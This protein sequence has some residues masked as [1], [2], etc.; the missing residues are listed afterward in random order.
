MTFPHEQRR[1]LQCLY[2]WA[3]PR[4]DMAVDL[5]T[6]NT[7]VY[8]RGKG[9]VLDEPYVVAQDADTGEITIGAD[10]RPAARANPET[11][12]AVRPL[13][14]SVMSPTSKPRRCDLRRRYACAV[15]WRSRGW[16]WRRYPAVKRAR[17]QGGR[18]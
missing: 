16:W 2:W 1:S 10:G 15:T 7:L 3:F 11:I 12:T 8:V 6:A 18:L 13:K 4:L 14:D 5:G 9:V 17:R